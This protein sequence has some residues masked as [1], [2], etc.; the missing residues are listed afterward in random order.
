MNEENLEEWDAS[1]LEEL[2]QVEEFAL[3]C[4][5]VNQDNR[6]PSSSFLP[7]EPPPSSSS[8]NQPLHFP[9]P[10]SRTDPISYSPPRELSQRPTELVGASNSSG[11]VAKCATPSTTARRDGGSANTKDLEIELLKKELGRVSKQLA[12]LEHECSELK[13]ERNK[14]DQLTVSNS[15][16]EAKI[17]NLKAISITDREHGIPVDAHD[18]VVQKF[19]NRKSFNDPISLHTVKSSCQ[20]IGVHTD[21]NASLNLCEKLQDIWGLPS[22]Q[23]FGR[24]LISKLFAV[25]SDD[26]DVLFGFINMRSP[27]KTL[28]LHAVKSSVNMTLK[29]S[30]H[31]FLSA[32]A[33]KVSR[34]YS[35]LTKISSGMLQLQ[36]LFESLFDLCTAENVVIVYRS[37]HIL[38][39]LLKHLVTF[40]RESRG[41]ENFLV[42]HLHSGSGT[43]DIFGYETRDRACI[44]MDG[45]FS[46][47]VPTG[48]GSSEA[49]YPCKKGCYDTSSA[50][51]FSHINW[52]YLFEFMR[53]ILMKSVEEC[54]R[55]EAVSIMNV[56]LMRSDAYTEREKFGLSQVFECISQLLKKEAGLLV[57]KE[58]VHALYLLLNC[59]KLVVTFCS[60]CTTETNADDAYDKGNTDAIQGF[61]MILEGLADCIVFSGNTLQALDLRKNAI[62]LLAFVASS[63]KSGFDIL[64][65]NKLS[66]EVN[67]LTLI[68][69]L[70][71][72][73][74]DM[75]ATV[76]TESNETLRARTLLI[77]EV[78]ILL[79][80]LV[81]NPVQSAT[82]LRLLTNSRDMVS[83]TIDVANRLSRKEPKLRL[84]DHITKQMRESEI[85][86]LGRMFKRRV[87]TYL[88]E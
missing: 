47:Y 3:S 15:N 42:E 12:D 51:L 35:A 57:Q 66:R 22:E 84:F 63:G 74:I 76:S 68:M 80:R 17:A 67:F 13:K 5:Y 60:G 85:V 14:E 20:A 18:R 64:V 75:E 32:E 86:D 52:I 9:P 72:S 7:L 54:V 79:N 70:L 23:K 44:G 50:P 1:F 48:V 4:S 46:S 53:L 19:P 55:L 30:I 6:T 81:S 88:G 71:A 25:C 36:A 59:P 49:K 24:N 58:A 31:P 73:E 39:V 37:L 11:F 43:D 34:F 61:T 26:I 38:H 33:A 10:P 69:Q 56:I 27:S 87:S 77:R 45:A 82:V 2:I 78:L 29:S 21:L 16:N 41:R 40:E 83:L 28:E 62:T 8:R 65:N